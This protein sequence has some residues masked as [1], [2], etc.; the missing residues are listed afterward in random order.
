M[1]RQIG[2]PNWTNSMNRLKND[3][4]LSY[5]IVRAGYYEE[6]TQE[7]LE[8]VIHETT[9]AYIV[10]RVGDTFQA[11]TYYNGVKVEIRNLN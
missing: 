2:E 1:Q 9:W 6:G 10:H 11:T 5:A 3:A 4:T 8:Q 7:L